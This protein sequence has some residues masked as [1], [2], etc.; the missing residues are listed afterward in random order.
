MAVI[1]NIPD[2]LVTWRRLDESLGFKSPL[3]H[4][5]V[6]FDTGRFK[7]LPRERSYESDNI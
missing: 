7:A 4:C 3:P 1:L 6:D 5:L 2:K